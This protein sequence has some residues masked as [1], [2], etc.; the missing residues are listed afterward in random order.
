M[1]SRSNFREMLANW[2]HRVKI[3]VPSRPGAEKTAKQ[4]QGLHTKGHPDN[5]MSPDQDQMIL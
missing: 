4:V 1:S 2:S 5:L 3:R